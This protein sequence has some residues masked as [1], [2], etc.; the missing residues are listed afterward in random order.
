MVTILS[1]KDRTVSVKDPSASIVTQAD[2]AGLPAPVRRYLTYS[3][4]VG[5]PRIETVRLKYAG[6]FRMAGDKP[7]IPLSAEQFYTTNPP[8]F[9]W[10]AQ[11]RFAGIPFM[12]GTDVYKDGHSHMHG[13][14]LGLFTV[15]DGQGE[16]VDQGAMVRYLQEMTWFPCAYLNDYITWQAVDDHAAD[17]TFHDNGK[18]V[19]LRM[20]FDDEGR[21]LACIAQ[22][23]GEF[24]GQYVVRTWATPITEYS[25]FNGLNIP[26]GGLGV[27]QL[28]SGDF[29]YINVRLTEIAYNQPIAAF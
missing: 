4:I 12:F 5:R 17:V 26:A 1:E 18:S 23:Y 20:Y 27:W 29:P 2:L 10:K 25:T 14:L 24:N 11:F 22:R 28:P 19:T 3:G 7:W 21:M 9:L 13:K 16:E 15:V 8:G 6:S